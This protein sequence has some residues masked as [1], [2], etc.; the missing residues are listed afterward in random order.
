MTFA[1]R[2]RYWSPLLPLLGLLGATYWLNQQVQPDS[3]KPDNGKRHDPDA[4]MENFSAIRLNEQGVPRFIMSAKKMLHYPDDDS[5]VLEV[6][7]FAML[8]AGHPTIRIIARRGIV[9]SK[10]DEIFLHNDVEVLREASVQQEELTLHTEYLHIIPDRD[11]ADTDQAVT[12]VDAHN[13]VH[14]TGL[15]MDNKARTLKLL[16]RVRSEH[17]PGKK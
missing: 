9:S 3:V 15:E 4:V 6:P 5:T 11:W 2:A 13:T 14:A 8:S 7:R 10:G 16:S 17:A 12:I 1:S